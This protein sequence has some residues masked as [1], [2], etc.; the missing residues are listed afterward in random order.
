MKRYIN[1]FLSFNH[2]FREERKHDMTTHSSQSNEQPDA[3]FNNSTSTE[4][5]QQAA[6]SSQ[7]SASQ[8]VVFPQESEEEGS[9]P[10]YVFDDEQPDAG[11]PFVAPFQI[12]QPM[13]PAF[14]PAQP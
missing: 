13:S 1:T 6:T 2:L 9:Q 3:Q 12:S 7:P 11:I 8:Q 14:A 5:E 10:F 4:E